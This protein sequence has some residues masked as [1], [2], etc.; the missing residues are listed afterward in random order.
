MEIE[1]GDYVVQVRI[2]RD[3]P[4]PASLYPLPLPAPPNDPSPN[5]P[6]PAVPFPKPTSAADSRKKVQKRTEFLISASV[7]ANFRPSD[8]G[9]QM[10]LAEDLYHGVDL[11]SMEMAMYDL[12][13]KF[14]ADR[15]AAFRPAAKLDEGTKSEERDGSTGKR[16]EKTID[17]AGKVHLEENGAKLPNGLDHKE[18]NGVN[19]SDSPT[20]SNSLKTEMTEELVTPPPDTTD[21]KNTD[22]DNNG[23]Q[24][25]TNGT[26]NGTHEASL[27]NGINH[28]NSDGPTPGI[29]KPAAGNGSQQ[30]NVM[31]KLFNPEF[32]PNSAAGI[33][34]PPQDPSIVVHEGYTCDG[35]G[36]PIIGSRYHCLDVACPDY[37]LCG[38]C[39]RL[40]V[41]NRDHQMLE[42]KESNRDLIEDLTA[43]PMDS[44]VVTVGLKVYAFKDCEV[45]MKGQLRHKDLIR[46]YATMSKII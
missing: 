2:D 42:I 39:V 31:P 34:F 25:L 15:K 40:G 21:S 43:Y 36:G 33:S 3:P 28:A 46:N 16:D 22:T 44:D 41:H 14:N 18:D 7:A 30:P 17:P 32:D 6:I 11:T 10:P 8:Y 19:G 13:S 12:Q 9:V 24:T 27:P 5:M 37:D 35:H 26:A 45:K 1:A 23:T 20:S 29:E 4:T 38:N